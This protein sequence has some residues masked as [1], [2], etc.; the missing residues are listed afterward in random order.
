MLLLALLYL[1]L[2]FRLALLLG[3]FPLCLLLSQLLL[4]LALLHLGLLLSL[5]LL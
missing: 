1:G 4:L 3:G 2:L 5:L